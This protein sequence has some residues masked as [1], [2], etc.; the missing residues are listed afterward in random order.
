MTSF[1]DI[2]QLCVDCLF[3]NMWL[4]IV[5]GGLVLL[6]WIFVNYDSGI[7]VQD[8]PQG[9]LPRSPAEL[10]VAH[11]RVLII[12]VRRNLLQG[13]EDMLDWFKPDRLKFLASFFVRILEFIYGV[14]GNAWDLLRSLKAALIFYFVLIPL[15]AAFMPPVG[16]QQIDPSAQLLAAT[17]I[18]IFL[19]AVGDAFSVNFSVRIVRSAL[20]FTTNS[21][22]PK[23]SDIDEPNRESRGSD[24][25]LELK[26]YLLLLLDFIVASGFLVLVLMGSSVMYGVQIGEYP[27]T[28][29]RATLNLMFE[30]AMEFD[31]L[32]GALYWFAN[33]ADG[34]LGQPGIP[35]MLFFS[36]TTFFPTMLIAVAAIIWLLILPVRV[37][38]TSGIGRFKALIISQICVFIICLAVSVTNAIDVRAAYAFIITT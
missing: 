34:F 14:R 8:I 30:S 10:P 3:E 37:L 35:G 33:D 26:F 9:M 28:L 6:L 1:A 31:R 5:Y 11:V 2:L 38:V 7:R 27:L 22:D 32:L 23:E 15:P 24:V 16:G 25:R 13:L 17:I 20:N 4:L 12:N 21:R 29:D 19:N 36:V 18:L